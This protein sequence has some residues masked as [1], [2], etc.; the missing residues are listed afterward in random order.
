MSLEFN[1]LD[2]TRM[3]HSKPLSFAQ[4]VKLSTPLPIKKIPIREWLR[5]YD[6]EE[7]INYF[8]NTPKSLGKNFKNINSIKYNTDILKH[9][10]TPDYAFNALKPIVRDNL[11][12]NWDV[13]E[14]EKTNLVKEH[15]FRFVTG[16][17]FLK[18]QSADYRKFNS[19]L[20]LTPT[21]QEYLDFIDKTGM[22]NFLDTPKY[23]KLHIFRKDIAR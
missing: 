16:I 18:D 11:L 19:P 15:L 13:P 12:N 2:R 23:R 6:L 4:V 9:L 7:Y 20:G 21:R 5:H 8:G 1:N 17:K 14:L 3:K 22:L 10:Y